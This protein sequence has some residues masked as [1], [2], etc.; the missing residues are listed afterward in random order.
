MCK[1]DIDK[2][3][4]DDD[5][6]GGPW[7]ETHRAPWFLTDDLLIA[8]MNFRAPT[9]PPHDDLLVFSGCFSALRLLRL[10]LICP[11]LCSEPEND[12]SIGL[13]K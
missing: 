1:V 12:S 7:V 11:D 10:G 13:K 5:D 9:I 3:N 6:N 4:D 8:A 2:A